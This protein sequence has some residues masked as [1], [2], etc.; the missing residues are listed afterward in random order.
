ML[1]H[2]VTVKSHAADIRTVDNI[3]KMKNARSDKYSR[4]QYDVEQTCMLP[5]NTAE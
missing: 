4:E 2:R 1:S 3:S 5:K